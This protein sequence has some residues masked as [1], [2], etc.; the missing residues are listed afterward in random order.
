MTTLVSH[1][2]PPSSDVRVSSEGSL[3]R[4]HPS[5]S[6]P[7]PHPHP[8]AHHAATATATA[9]STSTPTPS[10]Y[11]TPTLTNS[12]LLPPFP[13]APSHHSQPT[14]EGGGGYDNVQHSIGHD[15]YSRTTAQAYADANGNGNGNGHHTN[16]HTNENPNP[17]QH[18]QQHNSI[19]LDHQTHTHPNPNL[20]PNPSSHPN[21]NPNLKP[22]SRSTNSSLLGLGDNTTARLGLNNTLA[23]RPDRGY[24]MPNL[25]SGGDGGGGVGVGGTAA[26]GGIRYVPSPRSEL[27]STTSTNLMPD[28]RG[29]PVPVPA[30]AGGGGGGSR[31]GHQRNATASTSNGGHTSEST[32]TRN[33]RRKH[34][35]LLRK[36]REKELAHVGSRDLLKLVMD[37]E[38]DAERMRKLIRGAY[39]KVEE[40]TKKS[41]ELERLNQDALH[42]FKLLQESRLQA[43]HEA[44]IAAEEVRVYREQL[45]EA[46]KEIGKAEEVVKELDRKKVEMEKEKERERLENE[47]LRKIRVV[48]KAREEG[49]RE[50][51]ETGFLQAHV[52]GVPP[53]IEGLTSPKNVGALGELGLG[54][55]STMKGGRNAHGHGLHPNRHQHQPRSFSD[56]AHHYGYGRKNDG[57]TWDP[58]LVYEGDG[59]EEPNT[60]DSTPK[61]RLGK[62]PRH[63]QHRDG[64]GGTVGYGGLS[65]VPFPRPLLFPEPRYTSSKMKSKNKPHQA[66]NGNLDPTHPNPNPNNHSLTGNHRN[67]PNQNHFAQGSNQTWLEMEG[68]DDFQ[69]QP[70]H[71][72]EHE[73][74]HESANDYDDN[75]YGHGHGHGQGHGYGQQQNVNDDDED[76]GYNSSVVPTPQGYERNLPAVV[77]FTSAPPPPPPSSSFAAALGAVGDHH[78]PYPHHPSA[79]SGSGP[80]SNPG[81]TTATTQAQAPPPEA[82]PSSPGIQVYTI[83]IPTQDHIERHYSINDQDRSTKNRTKKLSLTRSGLG[84]GAGSLGRRFGMGGGGG[85]ANGNGTPTGGGGVNGSV[86][87]AGAGSDAG[88]AGIGSGHQQLSNR[89]AMDDIRYII[90]NNLQ[91]I[92]SQ[93]FRGMDRL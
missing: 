28:V 55:P 2:I 93:T 5:Q 77:P 38:R 86:A 3:R 54:L 18:R 51:F 17:T 24:P 44:R 20:N 6:H 64:D 69:L 56:T 27:L 90:T 8:L 22:I 62:V 33:Q 87:G 72:R 30:T 29:V 13:A 60:P 9:A 49:R 15:N 12:K 46:K 66:G 7:H 78:P 71:E 88:G 63:F 89:K 42:R 19:S 26:G 37:Q 68:D 45:E 82:M 34:E 23:I 81:L 79:M 58:E 76:Y 84:R 75:D 11:N 73:H 52:G 25:T 4:Y 83:D 53:N 35:E 65:S 1:H 47:R 40:Q 41:Q 36:E 39:Q 80:G 50:G 70:E 92:I 32:E 67:D 57:P 61:G 59:Y 16:T 91:I 21:P 74:G 85:N 14:H 31:N 48:E 10:N 43:Q